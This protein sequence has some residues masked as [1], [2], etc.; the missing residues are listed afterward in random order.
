MTEWTLSYSK[1]LQADGTLQVNQTDKSDILNKS[2]MAKKLDFYFSLGPSSLWKIV[3]VNSL[4][5]LQL[6]PRWVV[7]TPKF[8]CLVCGISSK[9]FT[10][11]LQVNGTL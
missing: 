10:E 9:D 3:V 8:V 4:T 7:F 2:L 5:K 1:V 6:I 11:M